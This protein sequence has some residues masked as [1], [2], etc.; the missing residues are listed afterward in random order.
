MDGHGVRADDLARLEGVLGGLEEHLGPHVV[1]EADEQV[2]HLVEPPVGLPDP[3]VGGDRL[4]QRRQRPSAAAGSGAFEANCE[5]SS[6]PC[7][8]TA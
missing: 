1:G 7:D 8:V 3:L 2:L 5:G 4:R 6:G